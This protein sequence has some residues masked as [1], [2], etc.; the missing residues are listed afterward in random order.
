MTKFD[1]SATVFYSDQGIPVGERRVYCCGASDS[2]ETFSAYWPNTAYFCP[3]CG[4]IWGRAVYDFEFEYSPRVVGRPW[5]VESR[6][7]VKHGD[8]TFLA[9]QLLEGCSSELL[10]RELLALLQG[11][12][13]G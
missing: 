7:C 10:T 1:G 4:E 6:R 12:N 2:G 13:H 9:G 8:G 11:A 3:A 5:V